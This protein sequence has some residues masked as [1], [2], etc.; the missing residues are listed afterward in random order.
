MSKENHQRGPDIPTHWPQPLK[1]LWIAFS[2]LLAALIP[3][4]SAN[5]ATEF[6][7]EN[8]LAMVGRIGGLALFIGMLTL[9][10]NKT[11]LD[12]ISISPRIRHLRTDSPNPAIV[13]PN[14]I[15]RNI[16][17]FFAL[18]S[19]VIFGL[20]GSLLWKLAEDDSLLQE[21]RDPDSGANFL[22]AIA[23]GGIILIPILLVLITRTKLELDERGIRRVLTPLVPIIT[24]KHEVFLPW[25]EIEKIEPDVIE[26][27]PAKE[28]PVIRLFHSSDIAKHPRLDGDGYTTLLLNDL[29]AEPNTLLALLEDMHSHPN[30]RRRLADPDARLLLTPPPLRW[31]WAE[32]KRLKLDAKATTH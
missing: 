14:F 4:L 28:L 16:L 12:R 8:T 23:I 11:I 31:R 19:I 25:S 9:V 10:V 29:V 2:I 21:R 32:A 22:L 1:P 17:L 5:L 6:S 20:T 30:C 18:I 27:G 7:S 26:V 15:L 13:I 24:R 3:V